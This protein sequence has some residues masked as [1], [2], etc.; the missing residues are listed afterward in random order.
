MITTFATVIV[1]TVS[2]TVIYLMLV[3]PYTKK[4]GLKQLYIP[5]GKRTER[6]DTSPLNYPVY[7]PDGVI[8]FRKLSPYGTFPYSKPSSRSKT[9]RNGRRYYIRNRATG[10]YVVDNRNLT[11]R[12][13]RARKFR[14]ISGYLRRGKKY[15]GVD[16]RDPMGDLDMIS[17]EN[18]NSA[19]LYDRESG[20]LSLGER[21]LYD[22]R[23]ELDLTGEPD[24]RAQWDFL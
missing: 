4:Y 8:A 9:P 10:R 1:A 20:M 22:H 13:R 2:L 15:M 6:A 11:R 24:H 5:V 17:K 12:R 19:Y 7:H 16:W 23:G 3:N 18:L 14:Y 21:Y